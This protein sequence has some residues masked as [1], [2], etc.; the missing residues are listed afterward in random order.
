[1]GEGNKMTIIFGIIAVVIALI[2]YTIAFLVINR[3]KHIT[4]QVLMTQ[5]FG[6]FFD[7]TATLLMYLYRPGFSITFH[8][9]IGFIALFFMIV[10][11]V[12]T[13]KLNGEDTPKWFLLYSKVIYVYWVFVFFA[14]M[15]Q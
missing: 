7:I 15:T 3:K 2:F 10:K 8:G 6:V 1:M 11:T 14:G 9:M 13:Y 12:I 4:K 5:C